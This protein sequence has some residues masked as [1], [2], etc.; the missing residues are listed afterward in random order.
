MYK[1]NMKKGICIK[2][3]SEKKVCKIIEREKNMKEKRNDNKIRILNQVKL[4]F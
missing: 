1:L 2:S 4:A 3:K